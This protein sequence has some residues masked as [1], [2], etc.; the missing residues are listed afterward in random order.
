V[1]HRQ[2]LQ[3]L[4]SQ[5]K[6]FRS[7]GQSAGRPILFIDFEDILGKHKGPRK[8]YSKFV[9]FCIAKWGVSA[10]AQGNRYD[11]VLKLPQAVVN[12]PLAALVSIAQLHF[13]LLY[14]SFA[15]RVLPLDENA[16]HK[17]VYPSRSQ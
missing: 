6:T 5:L 10:S 3:P 14:S 17:K 11:S 9:V 7:I 13:I 15:G 16:S 12:Q 4:A 8:T 1:Q 2:A